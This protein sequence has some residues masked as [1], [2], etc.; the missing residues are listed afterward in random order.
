MRCRRFPG[1]TTRITLTVTPAMLDAVCRT[2][3]LPGHPARGCQS[4][5]VRLAIAEK[6]ARDLMV[7]ASA[8]DTGKPRRP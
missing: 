1:A 2:M 7:S 4:E 8:P 6:I 3:N 5:F